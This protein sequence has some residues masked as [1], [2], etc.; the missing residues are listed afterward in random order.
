M[1]PVPSPQWLIGHGYSNLYAAL[2]FHPEAF[3]G[4]KQDRTRKLLAEHITSMESLAK[5]HGTLPNPMWL[6]TNG[7]AA[8]MQMRRKYPEAFA[9]IKQE[10]KR[11][12]TLAEHVQDARQLAKEHVLC[13]IQGG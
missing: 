8:A 3:A 6:R 10:S 2:R 9:H 12:R 5:Q 4:M 1:A 13:P 11:G 7:Y